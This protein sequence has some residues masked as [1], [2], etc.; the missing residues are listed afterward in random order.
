MKN[1]LR[2]L[3]AGALAMLGWTPATAATINLFDYA[4]NIDG[5]ITSQAAPA[6]VNVGAF[7][8][9]TGLGTVSIT[10]TGAG[11]HHV[12]LIVDHEIDEEENTFFNELGT[13]AGA[14]A[15]G[16]S[17][18]IDEPGFVF[19][20][21]YDNFLAGTLDDSIGTTEPEDVSMAIAW[22]FLLAADE[23]AL[24]RFFLSVD[25]LT[26]LVLTQSDPDSQARVMF[27][28]TLA[29]GGGGGGQD[30]PE[31][32]ALLLVGAALLAL[33]GARRKRR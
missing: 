20:D 27:S 32:S 23:T 31:P 9:V 19:G 29:I 8:T 33:L 30:L 17:W 7:D 12:S 16:Q 10:V 18:E 13:V 1:T 28:S 4:F 14:P 5:T 3:L 15:A 25:E 24:V 21:I 11:N 22:D 26:G 6:G 2:L